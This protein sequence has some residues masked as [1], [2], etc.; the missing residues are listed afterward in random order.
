ME[1]ENC[2]M[3]FSATSPMIQANDKQP[4]Q[5][6]DETDITTAAIISQGD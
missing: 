6:S 5:S 4:Q 1:V 2:S 3:I